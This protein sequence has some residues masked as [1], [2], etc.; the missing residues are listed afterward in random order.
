MTPK[1]EIK[2][3]QPLNGKYYTT[4]EPITGA[5]LVKSDKAM[6]IQKIELTLRGIAQTLVRQERSDYQYT[7][8]A[9]F[10]LRSCHVLVDNK[11]TLFPPANVSKAISE[12]DK[13]FTLAKGSHEYPFQFLVPYQPRCM[14]DH[15]AA[16][17]GFNCNEEDARIP[18]SFNTDS[19]QQEL[20]NV[21][22]YYYKMGTIHYYFKAQIFM[23][24]S[25]FRLKPFNPMV[26][27]YKMIEFIPESMEEGNQAVN[28]DTSCGPTDK[29]VSETDLKLRGDVSAWVEVRAKSLNR[30]HRM[31]YL[32]KPGCRRFDRIYLMFTD[33]PASSNSIKVTKLKLV[34]QE[35]LDYLSNGLINSIQGKIPLIEV[36]LDIT[37][38]PSELKVLKNGTVE[39]P[40]SIAKTEPLC[41]YRFNEDDMKYKGNGLYSFMCCN[42]RRSFKF[43]LKVTVEINGVAQEVEVSA[44]ST[45]IDRKLAIEQEQLPRYE[46]DDV[47]P[48]YGHTIASDN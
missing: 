10:P 46:P 23:G 13:A 31:D 11:L 42:I 7:M 17:S 14:T 28:V 26:E 47:P 16:T 12:P 36:P 22:A 25:K 45:K 5:L 4:N 15:G 34:L 21:E 20:D 24:K 3:N 6:C 38:D 1:A 2:L 44:S 39:W 41:S 43:L 40:L 19:A 27:A 18:P 37:L 8:N 9:G 48:E 35:V 30:V 33:V 29:F 32:F